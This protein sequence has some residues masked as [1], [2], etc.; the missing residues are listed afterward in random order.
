VDD[1]A[2]YH[3]EFTDLVAVEQKRRRAA[4]SGGDGNAD[5]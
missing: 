5:G 2:A 3:R 1:T 4:G